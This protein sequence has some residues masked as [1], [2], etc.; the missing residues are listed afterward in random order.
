VK[1]TRIETLEFEVAEDRVAEV[2]RIVER[3]GG[4]R[5]A[6]EEYLADGDPH[7][8]GRLSLLVVLEP[9]PDGTRG[10]V[11]LSREPGW[12]QATMDVLVQAIA[13]ARTVH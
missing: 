10:A 13:E 3:C 8:G 1:G 4:H 9:R 12:V 5:M 11:L 6:P 7:G 2:E